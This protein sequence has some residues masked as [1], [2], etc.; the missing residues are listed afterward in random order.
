MLRGWIRVEIL[1]V[2][3]KGAGIGVAV[4]VLLMYLPP[5]NE[6]WDSAGGKVWAFLPRLAPLSGA[7]CSGSP[8]VVLL[9]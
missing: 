7:A 3:F 1:V 9:L 8:G 4:N 5:S 6:K 2:C